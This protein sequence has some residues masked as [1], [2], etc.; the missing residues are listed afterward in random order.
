MNRKD[1]RTNSKPVFKKEQ[2][3]KHETGVSTPLRHPVLRQLIDAVDGIVRVSGRP[4]KLTPLKFE[5]EVRN[6]I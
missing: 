5:A 4:G 6:C 2:A 1:D 3:L